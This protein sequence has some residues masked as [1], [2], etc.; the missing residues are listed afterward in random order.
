MA[1][2]SPARAWHLLLRV[3]AAV[4]LAFSTGAIASAVHINQVRV[5]VGDDARWAQ[6]GYDDSSWPVQNVRQLDSQD[7]LIWIRTEV[8]R[9]SDGPIAVNVS[10]LGAYQLFWNGRLIGSS[11]SPGKSRATERPGNVDG[12]FAVPADL[13]KD[14]NLLAVRISTFHL[15]YRMVQPFQRI[16]VSSYEAGVTAPIRTYLASITVAGFLLLSGLYFAG[17]H[18]ADRSRRETLWLTLMPL[19][20]LGQLLLE[21]LRGF[22]SYR[23]DLHVLRVGGVFVLAALFVVSL[24]SFVRHA[25]LEGRRLWLMWVAV[26]W[27]IA[28]GFLFSGFDSKSVAA[29][30][31][32]TAIFTAALAPVA[33]RGDRTALG[34]FL[35]SVALIVIYALEP[36]A[37]LDR[38]LFIFAAAA[39]ITI[40]IHDVRRS[41]GVV[42]RRTRP[43]PDA[44]ENGRLPVLSAKGVELVDIAEIAA[45]QGADDYAETVSVTGE[46]RLYRGRLADLETFLP[47]NFVR[48]HRSHIVNADH[49]NELLSV[50]GALKLRMGENLTV[51]VSRSY[52]KTAR[53][54]FVPRAIE[55]LAPGAA[56]S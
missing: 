1:I 41:R 29:I 33:S 18:V 21:V 5:Q 46:K 39:G 49:V 2:L 32:G 54:I 43:I 16:S 25:F 7:R 10:A 30:L 53:Q 13:V 55:R 38:N 15:P 28:A 47:A 6:P 22:V 24:L 23:Y 27:I 8:G 56:Q 48:V 12:H 51:P 45:V 52:S 50:N 35:G 11:G 44:L 9:S 34:W 3:I 40:L 4:T 36:L 17:L 37:F 26:G 20:L 14:R 19:A 31:G 42:A